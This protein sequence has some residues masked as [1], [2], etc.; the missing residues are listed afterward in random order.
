MTAFRWDNEPKL[1]KTRWPDLKYYNVKRGLW[2]IV[3]APDWRVVGPHYASKAELLA[4]LTR[5]ATEYGVTEDGCVR[6][7]ATCAECGE[8]W[9]CSDSARTD[10][11][12]DLRARHSCT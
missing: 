3:V 2:R 12:P 7:Q 8:Y 1:N 6:E 11:R 5:Y 4:D 10:I 9:P